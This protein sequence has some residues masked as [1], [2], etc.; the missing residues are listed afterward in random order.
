V[1]GRWQVVGL[2]VVMA[3]PVLALA[4]MLGDHVEQRVVRREG[5][6]L[7]AD[8]PTCARDGAPLQIT[9]RLSR[10]DTPAVL[11]AANVELSPEYL[12]RF[13]EVKLRPSVFGTTEESAA[14]AN[15]QPVV[16][17]L[18]PDRCGWARGRLGVTTGTG[19]RMEL[20]LKTF[21]FP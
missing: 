3:V 1:L 15:A 5:W 11:A 4:E 17:E 19:V 8:V 7:N 16:I 18:T 10:E 9:V 14:P 21:V 12:S 2:A 6:I 13:T 20:E